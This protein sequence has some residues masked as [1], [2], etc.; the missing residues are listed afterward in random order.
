MPPATKNDQFLL[1]EQVSR[2][3]VTLWTVYGN[4]R[5]VTRCRYPA[6]YPPLHEGVPRESGPLPKWP[7]NAVDHP[8]HARIPCGGLE[9]LLSAG[10]VTAAA[11]ARVKQWLAYPLRSGLEHRRGLM[12]ALAA[13]RAAREHSLPQ[14]Q[15]PTAQEILESVP[16]ITNPPGAAVSWEDL[17]RAFE[18]LDAGEE[19]EYVGAYAGLDLL[20]DG[21]VSGELPVQIFRFDGSSRHFGPHE[22]RSVLNS[23]TP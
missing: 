17:G 8:A 12:A 13:H 20:A 21:T 10:V 23:P 15:S 7:V 1:Y 19:I 4:L 22:Q 18:L 14:G 11:R 6:W 5:T 3:M 9:G 16:A 2:G